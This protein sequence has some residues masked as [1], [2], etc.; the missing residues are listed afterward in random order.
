MFWLIFFSILAIVFGL[1]IICALSFQ[2]GR[3][4]YDRKGESFYKRK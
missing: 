3:G 4:R 1:I 2:D